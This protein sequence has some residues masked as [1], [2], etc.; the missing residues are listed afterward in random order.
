[1][2]A[3]KRPT[4][5]LVALSFLALTA[6][7][8]GGGG[9]GT[10]PTS[11]QTN[12]VSGVA[13][14]GL[15]LNG[16]VTA[17]A[18]NSDGSRGAILQTKRTSET[19]GSYSFTDLPKGVAILIEV[20]GVANET[21]MKDEATGGTLP[22]DSTFKLRA[23][24]VTGNSG[25]VAV[26]ITPYSEMAVALAVASGGLSADNVQ[27]AN[28]KVVGFAGEDVL[29]TPPT[30]DSNGK[31]TNPAAVKL[32][33][34][35]ELAN[36]AGLGCSGSQLAKVKC[37]VN[38]MATKGPADGTLATAVS[39]ATDTVKATVPE[40]LK[41]KVQPVTTQL[42]GLPS[43]PVVSAI[44]SA[45]ALITSFRNLG[46]SL[47]SK[48]AGSLTSRVTRLDND[49]SSLP[50]V[51]P[52]TLLDEVDLVSRALERFHRFQPSAER[53][54]SE[55]AT[56][57]SVRCRYASATTLDCR[58]T[59]AVVLRTSTFDAATGTYS[60]TYIGSQYRA[61]LTAG[62]S[63]NVNITTSLVKQQGSGFDANGFVPDWD[64]APAAGVVAQNFSAVGRG[65]GDGV[66]FSGELAPGVRY[67]YSGANIVETP[68]GAKVSV[69]LAVA[70]PVAGTTSDR[71]G[72]SG[73][74]KQFALATDTE[75]FAS[76]EIRPGSYLEEQIAQPSNTT[77]YHLEFVATAN[78]ANTANTG[79]KVTGMLDASKY[80]PRERNNLPGKATFTGTI[81][82]LIDNTTLFEGS[83][84][85][86]N[87]INPSTGDAVKSG[88]TGS[89]T[90]TLYMPNLG[91][92]RNI[93][94]TLN[95]ITETAVGEYSFSGRF[96]DG[97]TLVTF[98]GQDKAGEAN[99]YVNFASNGVNFKL[100]PASR[101]TITPLKNGSG[102]VIGQYD[103]K[104]SQVTYADGSYEQF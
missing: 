30:F 37:V 77:A 101:N 66:L 27:K 7:G 50:D 83:V 20:T 73:F 96:A 33:A 61:L 62:S 72:V 88:R 63:G 103:D 67:D 102:D 17:Y 38:E 71:Y 49:L 70:A 24:T 65:S 39:S 12:S 43:G 93:T 35:S 8:G 100:T 18:V 40:E 22:L 54:G 90:L 89:F 11:S 92:N 104:K 1:M 10:S 87:L 82:D 2:L 14:K 29:S 4:Q 81:V 25:N 26:Q 45:Q 85:G 46:T 32:A 74:I 79:V 97:T 41:A 16:V 75:P 78:K 23:A 47:A 44:T 5:A 56:G 64:V 94:L 69:S 58:T 9:G 31:P 36:A 84:T 6:C 91:R 52:E 99:D 57:Y 68:Q 59:E 86:D 53:V 55:F 98:D 60:Y 76:A 21:T 34:V 3:T 42:P 51:L 15:I 95:D 48:D 13:S 28:Q 19:D 80:L